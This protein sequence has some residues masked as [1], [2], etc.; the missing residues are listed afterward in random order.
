MCN[1]LIHLG[2]FSRSCLS[3]W[4]VTKT[5]SCRWISS[6]TMWLNMLSLQT[7]ELR[8]AFA[9]DL[10]LPITAGRP[11]ANQR[12]GFKDD[13]KLRWC[14]YWLPFE[15]ELERRCKYILNIQNEEYHRTIRELVSWLERTETNIQN[16]EP[17][18]LTVG[19]KQLKAQLTKFQVTRTL[20]YKYDYL[21]W[22]MY[23]PFHP[24]TYTL[25]WA[26]LNPA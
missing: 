9:I 24:R 12:D 22:R 18:D 6:S 17:I 14:R 25:N 16:A 15:Q 26:N 21:Y 10:P 20:W 3:I 4:I 1:F 8:I 23:S 13:F 2:A 7:Y 19:T 5:S 11:S